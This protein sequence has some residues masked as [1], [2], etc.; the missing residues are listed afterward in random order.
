MNP[1]ISLQQISNMLLQGQLV[2]ATDGSC[3]E[4][5]EAQAWCLGEKIDGNI[6]IKGRISVNN[7][8]IDANSTRPEMFG[9]IAIISF[10]AH[11]IELDLQ[12]N[13]DHAYPDL[14]LFTDSATSISNSKKSHYPST[15][16]VLE[17]NIDAKI[18][19]SL[20]LKKI[21]IKVKCIHVRA[22]QDGLID[23]E[24]MNLPT[25]LNTL[26]DE[27][28]GLCYSKHNMKKNPHF[29]LCDHLPAQQVSFRLPFDRPTTNIAHRLCTFRSSHAAETELARMLKINLKYL[30]K[31]NW[32]AILNS[33][34]KNSLRQKAMISKAVYGQWCTM[35]IAKRFNLAKTNICSSCHAA[36]ETWQHVLQCPETC[37]KIHRNQKLANIRKGLVSLKTS[38][39][40][41]NRIMSMLYQLCGGYEVTTPKHVSNHTLMQL[42]RNN[43]TLDL[44]TSLKALFQQNLKKPRI[45]IIM[46]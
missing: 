44:G 30:P 17:T 41:K 24:K 46:K 45:H 12:K 11:I 2:A 27:H 31:I 22:H 38:N 23:W 10:V 16:N 25:Q 20:L 3:R 5:K 8:F 1:W 29:E 14:L 43:N 26:M 32:E 42:L 35:K 40:L 18:E 13:P 6:V 9:I 28:V 39:V 37:R 7:A 4:G 36:P 15:K 34:K 19:L 33:V 21:P